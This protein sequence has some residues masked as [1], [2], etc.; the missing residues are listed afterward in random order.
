MYTVAARQLNVFRVGYVLGDVLALRGRDGRVVGVVE[1]EGWHA[2]CRKHRP[3]IQFG[4]ERH[5]ESDGPWARRQAFH[6]SPGCPDLLVPRHVRIQQMLEL[7][8]APHAEHRSLGFR[9]ERV[10]VT[11][12][13][14]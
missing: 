13:S 8:A 6:S 4:H 11:P 10:G 3:H 9:L 14:A 5:H 1:D 7:P 2:D 12:R